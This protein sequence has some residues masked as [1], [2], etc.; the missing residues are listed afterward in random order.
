MA[1]HSNSDAIGRDERLLQLNLLEAEVGKRLEKKRLAADEEALRLRADA[2]KA[3]LVNGDEEALALVPSVPANYPVSPEES[4]KPEDKSGRAILNDVDGKEFIIFKNTAVVRMLEKSQGFRRA[5][6]TDRLPFLLGSDGIDLVPSDVLDCLHMQ[7]A[8]IRNISSIETCKVWE[9]LKVY[10]RIERFRVFSA[11]SFEAFTLFQPQ[12]SNYSVLALQHFFDDSFD[13]ERVEDIISAL[14]GLELTLC[15]IFGYGWRRVLDDLIIRV[16]EGDL[17]KMLG[18][19]LRHELE[20]AWNGFCMEMRGRSLD[21][22]GAVRLLGTQYDCVSLL[23]SMYE[24]VHLTLKGQERFLRN[25]KRKCTEQIN[26]SPVKASRK[27]V[28]LGKISNTV[29]NKHFGK[30]GTGVV[31]S[32][33]YCVQHLQALFL[34]SDACSKGTSCHFEHAASKK[35]VQKGVLLDEIRRSSAKILNEPDVRADL[36]KAVSRS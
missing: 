5:C 23:S 24:K 1:S 15:F 9:S 28:I 25:L 3:Y 32:S 13:E 36:L 20:A 27:T 29:A 7:S 31:K 35:S 10:H 14:R 6:Q 8:R 16:S 33:G 22:G 18:T 2:L 30:S 21:A 19:Y 26:V 11:K 34:G 4:K 17:S 12:W